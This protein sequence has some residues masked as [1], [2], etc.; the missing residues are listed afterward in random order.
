MSVS[1][2]FSEF[3]SNLV[4]SNAEIISTRYGEVTAA[5]NKKFRDTESIPVS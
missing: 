1:S 2:M 5:L 4:I 3:I